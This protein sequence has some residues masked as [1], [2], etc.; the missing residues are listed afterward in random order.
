MEFTFQKQLDLLPFFLR[1]NTVNFFVP[2]TAFEKMSFALQELCLEVFPKKTL[3]Q[4][5]SMTVPKRKCIWVWA[6]KMN[7]NL[8]ISH[9]PI[10]RNRKKD[11]CAE[12]V[13]VGHMCCSLCLLKI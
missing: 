2:S 6:M 13:D 8:S 12:I 7:V 10:K 3:F 1:V 5:Q 4:K 11:F 9:T